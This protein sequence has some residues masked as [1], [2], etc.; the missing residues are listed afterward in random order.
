MSE[1]SAIRNPQPAIQG[2]FTLLELVVVLSIV[3]I[4]V[5]FV[6]PSLE[7]GFRQWRLQG[8]ARDLATTLKFTRNQSVAQR[9]SFQVV[10]DRS[11]NVYWLDRTDAPALA[12]PE[13]AEEKQVR[14]YALPGGVKFLAVTV[15]STRADGERVGILFSPRGNS[16]GGEVEIG[17]ERGR[18]YRVNV[19]PMTGHARVG[20]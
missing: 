12:E 8:A 14:L 18:T 17:D 2:G 20:R 10:F 3:G 19:D 1:K 11:R 13:Q 7:R 16:T 5:S 15:G 9:A 4:A 6:L